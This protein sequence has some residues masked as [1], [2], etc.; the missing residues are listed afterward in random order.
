MI[1]P[2]ETPEFERNY[3]MQYHRYKQEELDAYDSSK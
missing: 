3:W 1:F 2:P